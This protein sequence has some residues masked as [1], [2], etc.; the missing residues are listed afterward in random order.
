MIPEHRMVTSV[1]TSQVSLTNAPEVTLFRL[2]GEYT[3]TPVEML[4]SRVE[5]GTSP[6]GV[7][8]ATISARVRGI[9]AGSRKGH[10]TTFHLP[11][12]PA[13]SWIRVLAKAQLGE[14]GTP[15]L[16]QGMRYSVMDV[17]QC[18]TLA[19]SGGPHA[20]MADGRTM[21]VGMM[22]VTMA[23]HPVPVLD[24]VLVGTVE[25]GER[26]AMQLNPDDE[27]VPEWVPGLADRCVV[28]SFQG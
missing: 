26:T 4:V 28:G 20:V 19:L 24:V 18:V 5:L 27:G 10:T 9:M 6:G 16:P 7:D 3:M 23:T 22:M 14:V 25:S 13:P 11:H 2:P 8:R 12:D 17:T 21:V 15:A 1:T